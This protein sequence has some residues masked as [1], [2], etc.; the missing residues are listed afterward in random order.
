MY[1]F[2]LYDFMRAI[3]PIVNICI[4]LLFAKF[5]CLRGF[6]WRIVSCR[7]GAL[8]LVLYCVLLLVVCKSAP[9]ISIPV[10]LARGHIRVYRMHFVHAL[11]G[12][13]LVFG[14]VHA[15]FAFL[16][17]WLMH[18]ARP[19]RC[20][21]RSWSCGSSTAAGGVVGGRVDERW[22]RR[23][24][25]VGRMWAVFEP[26]NL[27]HLD[28]R[29]AAHATAKE[30]EDV[31]HAWYLFNVLILQVREEVEVQ[32]GAC[33]RVE[34]RKCPRRDI[35]GW[36]VEPGDTKALE[37]HHDDRGQPAREETNA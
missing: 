23:A 28:L 10:H 7:G 8:K 26:H 3:H 30:G 5:L 18:S 33:N 2:A 14:L 13:G 31:L 25:G 1:L 32:H 16:T 19:V 29:Q 34:G 12:T 11:P 36:G 4:V 6:H 27:S 35:H 20:S 17:I 15:S 9:R 22:P 21:S 37:D 24:Q